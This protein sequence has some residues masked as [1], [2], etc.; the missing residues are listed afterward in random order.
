MGQVIALR[1]RQAL[2]E[3]AVPFAAAM[4]EHDRA[5]FEA[6]GDPAELL[7][8]GIVSSAWSC[9]AEDA[10]GF[11]AVWGV[12]PVGTVLGGSGYCW[13][14]TT[15]RVLLHR[16]EFLQGSRAWVAAMR[17]EYRLLAGWCAVDYAVSLRWLTRWLGFRLGPTTLIGGVPFQNFWWGER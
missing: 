12:Q 2:V 6:V 17:A 16:R 13:C 15:P 1:T 14:A 4:R 10:E 11:V 7:A 3:D 8:E 9:L 5:E